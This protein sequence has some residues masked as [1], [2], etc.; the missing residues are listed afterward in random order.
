MAL[1]ASAEDD[2][3][4]FTSYQA[5]KF[6]D[7]GPKWGNPCRDPRVAGRIAMPTYNVAHNKMVLLALAA[8]EKAD[9]G[10]RS[11]KGSIKER[12]WWE[13]EG[14]KCVRDDVDY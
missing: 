7:E 5:A 11:G 4:K 2:D 8:V 3:F 10:R 1:K 14:E 12:V 6:Q 9:I 13:G